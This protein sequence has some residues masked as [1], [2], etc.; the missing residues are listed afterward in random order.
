MNKI[1]SLKKSNKIEKKYMVNI[2]DKMIHFGASGM[3]DFTIH[4]DPKR[5]ERYIKRHQKRENWT[6]KG[7]K[8]AG[9]W[10]RWLLWNKP[11]ISESKRDIS[12]RFKIKF[13]V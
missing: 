13:K 1:V 12:N 5:K 3:S 10:S 11:T 2:D 9:F 7:I 6:I 8:T 4:K